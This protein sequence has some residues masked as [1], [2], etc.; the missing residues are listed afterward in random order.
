MICV[1]LTFLL[2]SAVRNGIERCLVSIQLFSFYSA[3]D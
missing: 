3:C 2:F 1:R